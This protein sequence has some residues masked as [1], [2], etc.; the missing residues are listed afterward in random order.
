MY[1]SNFLSLAVRCISVMPSWLGFVLCWFSGMYTGLA[2]KSEPMICERGGYG[3]WVHVGGGWIWIE[4]AKDADAY[5]YA[6]LTECV[7]V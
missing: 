2:I 3:G 4:E 1:E 6:C 7:K 5:A